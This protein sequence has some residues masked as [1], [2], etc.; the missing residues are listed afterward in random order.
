MKKILESLFR[1]ETL[2]QTQAREIL[3]QM[4]QG[5]Y[6]NSQMSAFMTVFM[7]RNI[8]IEELAGFQQAMLD[9]CVRVDLQGLDTID[10]CG[11]GGD[12]KDTFN[13]S[14][15]SAFVL[16][17]TGI[18]VSKHGNHGVSSLAGSST[19][20]EYLGVKFTNDLSKLYTSLE[21][22]NVCF[23]HA[24]LFHPAMKNVAPI[25]KDLGVKTFFNMLGP[26]VNPAMPSHQ[27]V[28]VFSLELGRLY[29]YLYQNR[30]KENFNQKIKNFVIFHSIDG[31][32][33][34][35]LTSET[36]FFTKNHGEKLS[37]PAD[38]R[39]DYLKAEQLFGGKSIKEA[40]DIFIHILENK[41]TKAQEMAL[42]ANTTAGVQCYFPD[43]SWEESWA[44]AEESLKSGN[45]FTK[46][47]TF[48]QIN[49]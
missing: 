17:G 10:V 12:S 14:T 45:A 15:L 47:K 11:T 25:R 44:M 35:S 34:I 42:L 43:K 8:T 27:L 1:Y 26:M 13:I 28:G 29:Y 30:N 32:D 3:T 38:M 21:K 22:S 31:Y 20:L 16:A 2:S 7:M 4:A 33:E 24:P 48:L 6:N 36:K 46:F 5:G 40:G 9:L 49:Q 18:K 39:C 41:G 23:M 19:V 37:T